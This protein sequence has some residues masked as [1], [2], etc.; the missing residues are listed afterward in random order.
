MVECKR[1]DKVVCRFP[2]AGML[3]AMLWDK[4]SKELCMYNKRDVGIFAG[5]EG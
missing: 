1:Q 3:E 4:V 5:E 2:L